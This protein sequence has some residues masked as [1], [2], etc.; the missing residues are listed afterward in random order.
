M[1][2][3]LVT[4]RLLLSKLCSKDFAEIE[5]FEKRNQRHLSRWES[6]PSHFSEARLK[7]WLKDCQEGRAIRLLIREKETNRLIGQCNFTQIFHG[8]FKACYLG[9]KIDHAYEG[10]GMM[11]EALQ[12]AI[13]YI[14]KDV[15]LHRIMAN[16]MP[17]N[18]RSARLLQR[19][20]FTQEGY[21]K[22]YLFIN[23]RW[24]DH[25][26]TALSREDWQQ[27]LLANQVNAS[28]T[29]SAFCR[30]PQLGDVP[31]LASLFSQLGYPTDEYHVL[32]NLIKYQSLSQQKAWV[33]EES[34]QV[35]GCIA[36]SLIHYFHR[37]GTFLRII[38][39]VIDQSYRGKGIGRLLINQAETYA[40]NMGCSHIE[41]TS[42]SQRINAHAFYKALGYL[43]VSNEKRY[44]AKKI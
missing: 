7:E 40:K 21:A 14:F 8:F 27:R 1:Q 38:T 5:A 35:I 30:I 36:V 11:Y 33:A 18:V 39:L 19:L 37:P 23:S 17:L 13:S 43:D 22:N 10:K 3:L 31:A 24:E 41:L 12:A 25:V 15:G 32:A 4:E 34:G 26:L 6:F 2:A 28:K 44:L 16:Y 20:G 9:Y 42:G 29:Q